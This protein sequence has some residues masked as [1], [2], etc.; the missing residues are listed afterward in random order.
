MVVE[1]EVEEER[2]WRRQVV[3]KQ[4]ST[5]DNAMRENIQNRVD[6]PN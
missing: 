6:F 5:I 2:Y 3:S 4:S 1:E